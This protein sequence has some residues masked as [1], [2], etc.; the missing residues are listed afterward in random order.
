MLNR[1]VISLVLCFAGLAF[2]GGASAYFHN[3]RI[4]E[5]FSNADGTVQFIKL[6]TG[7]ADEN[8]PTLW[9]SDHRRSPRRRSGD[10]FQIYERPHR[11]YRQH[12]D[13]D[14]DAW[15]LQRSGIV[16]PDFAMPPGFLSTAGGTINLWAISRS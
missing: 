1:L 15:H 14:C 4:T 8:F 5:L 7:P 16:A 3:Y 2:S 6:V 10:T 13:P 11:K 9:P 12:H